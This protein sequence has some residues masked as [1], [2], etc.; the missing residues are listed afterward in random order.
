MQK[1]YCNKKLVDVYQYLYL[2]LN[3]KVAIKNFKKVKKSIAN[4]NLKQ[5]INEVLDGESN[6]SKINCKIIFD[7]LLRIRYNLIRAMK[8]HP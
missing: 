8:G 2:R 5:Y 7:I 6:K 3:Q 4:N 1:K